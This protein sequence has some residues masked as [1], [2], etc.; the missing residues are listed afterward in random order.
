MGGPEDSGMIVTDM[1]NMHNA[2]LPPQSRPVVL[3]RFPVKM[4]F[5]VIIAI[6]SSAAYL[7]YH[8][9][10]MCSQMDLNTVEIGKI[11]VSHEA[12]HKDVVTHGKTLIRVETN[13]NNLVK[14]MDK[15][16][17]LL[18]KIADRVGAH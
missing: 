8:Y 2:A 1:M 13:Q 18:G 15:Q 12:T 17:V 14:T 4:V 5:T 11:S 3:S 9:S 6:L 16:G 7:G 10:Q